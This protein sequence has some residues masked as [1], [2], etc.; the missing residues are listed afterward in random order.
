MEKLTRPFLQHLFG[1]GELHVGRA[2]CAL[3]FCLPAL[4]NAQSH[5]ARF[6]IL[7]G[8]KV[9]GQVF[10][11]KTQVSTRTLY[12]MS[13]YA[14][15]TLAWK[16]TVRTSMSTEYHDNVLN[17]CHMTVSV[18]DAMRDSSHMARGSDRCFV[19]PDLPFNCERTTQ[20]T[21]ARMYFEEPLGQK[22]IF[23]ESA[24]RD[25][26]LKYT[27][28]GTYVLTFPNGNSNTYMYRGG[29]LQEIHVKRPLV[30]LVFK[31]T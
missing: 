6:D 8:T 24:L 20:W 1:R 22:H 21:T 17:N 10:A 11:F 3:L 19:Y 9:L 2:L 7:R 25:L 4:M 29:I 23:V 13:S 28:Q 15:F 18:N 5:Q 16:Q 12:R 27:A 31:R 30:G 26:P 14:E